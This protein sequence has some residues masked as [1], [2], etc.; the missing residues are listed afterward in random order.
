MTNRTKKLMTSSLCG[1][2]VTL[3]LYGTAFAS[4]D[5]QVITVTRR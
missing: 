2:L 4:E 3:L 1:M 5:D